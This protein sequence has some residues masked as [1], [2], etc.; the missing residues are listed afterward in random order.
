M[1]RVTQV[2]ALALAASLQ[3]IGGAASQQRFQCEPCNSFCRMVL[4]AVAIP[5]PGFLPTACPRAGAS[6]LWCKIVLVVMALSRS[7]P[8]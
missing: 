1:V 2:A 7:K 6:L 5:Q 4:E 3:L 8:S